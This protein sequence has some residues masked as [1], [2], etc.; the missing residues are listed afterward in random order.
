MSNRV[1][2]YILF[3]QLFFSPLYGAWK[4]KI[5]FETDKEL[6]LAGETMLFSVITTDSVYKPVNFSKVAYI[7]LLS[8]KKSEAQVMINIDESTGSGQMIIP[9]N[10]STGHY[11]LVAYTSYMRNDGANNFSRKLIAI[12]NPM[13]IDIQ[14]L[15]NNPSGL[16]ATKRISDTQIHLNT[17]KQSYSKRSNG[18]LE[19]TQIPDSVYKLSVVMYKQDEVVVP[20]DETV[21]N[22]AITETKKTYL[23]EYEGHIVKGKIITSI[24]D[25]ISNKEQPEIYLSSPGIEPLIYRANSDKK[26]NI[27]FVTNNHSLTNDIVTVINSESKNKQV[28]DIESPFAGEPLMPLPKLTIDTI[29]VNQLLQ[30]SVGLQVQELFNKKTNTHSLTTQNNLLKPFKTYKLD[31][32]TRFSSLE[33][34]IIEFVTNV[35]FRKI[36]QARKLSVTSAEMGAFTLG[37]SLVLLDNIPVFDHDLLL[38]YNPLLIKTINIYVGKYV[39]GGSFFDGIVTFNTYKGDFSGFKLDA[40]TSVLNYPVM[41]QSVTETTT[42]TYNTG[43]NIPSNIPDFRHTLLWKPNIKT[44]GKNQ[45]TIPFSTSDYIGKFKIRVNILLKNGTTSSALHTIEVK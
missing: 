36:G 20:E 30:R 44:H 32:Y 22:L 38:K 42:P 8:D 26:D 41:Q 10:L 21:L 45:L 17:D 39:F 37:N 28:I 29:L 3:A 31:E 11:R 43:S 18:V 24:N 33:E 4:E 12:V 19:I 5:I 14:N 27:W 13:T 25:S 1:F 7:E 40:S 16:T 23:P 6:Y 34:V 15:K 35:K 2:I 9:S